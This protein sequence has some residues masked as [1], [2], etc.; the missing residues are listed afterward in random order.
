MNNEESKL[1]E[2]KSPEGKQNPVIQ[3]AMP[4][5]SSPIAANN[6]PFMHN[7][8]LMLICVLALITVV[9]LGLALFIGIPNKSGNAKPVPILRTTLS[10][11]TPIA[12]TA[13]YT[14]DITLTTERGKTTAVEIELKYDP[15]VLTNV[16]IQPGS[17]FTNP[18]VLSKTIDKVNG[19]V[20]YILATGL[21]QHPV[22]GNGTV[23]VLSFTP[24]TK[25]G[26]TTIAL[27]P[28]S[29][30]T[31]SGEVHSILTNAK[32]IQFPFGPTPVK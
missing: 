10:A 21:G 8:T 14:S 27:L 28:Q 12:S 11:L 9:L 24:L 30:V 19:K 4:E 5:P 18:T 17:F 13:N 29:K 25:S 32:G 16:D 31:V 1:N 20:S 22:N 3:P 6:K 26:I 2:V 15:K 7:K 23:A